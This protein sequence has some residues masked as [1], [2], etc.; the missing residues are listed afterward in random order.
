MKKCSVQAALWVAVLWGPW[1]SFK[2]SILLSKLEA[3]LVANKQHEN[4]NSK[5][6]EWSSLLGSQISSSWNGLDAGP[7]ADCCWCGLGLVSGFF[8][9]NAVNISYVLLPFPGLFFFL[10]YQCFFSS[11]TLIFKQCVWSGRL[12]QKTNAEPEVSFSKCSFRFVGMGN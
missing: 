11:D 8:L 4:L 12:K 6:W 9:S 10:L 1:Q 7:L 2:R 3:Y 5:T